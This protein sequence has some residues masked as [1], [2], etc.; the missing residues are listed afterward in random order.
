MLREGD[1]QIDNYIQCLECSSIKCT[2]YFNEIRYHTPPGKDSS[3]DELPTGS[4][5]ETCF[6]A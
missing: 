4:D 2:R 5:A 1:M 3:G 6:I